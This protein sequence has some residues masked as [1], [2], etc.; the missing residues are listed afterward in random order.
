MLAAEAR[1]DPMISERRNFN[2][3]VILGMLLDLLQAIYFVE[4]VVRSSMDILIPTKGIGDAGN[5]AFEG[6]RAI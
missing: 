2:L 4:R 3:D 5:H 6:L 1:L